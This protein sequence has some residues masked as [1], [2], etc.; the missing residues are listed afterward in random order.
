MTVKLS[1]VLSP[2]VIEAKGRGDF[3]LVLPVR[4]KEELAA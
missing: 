3:A 4:L 2:I 1:G